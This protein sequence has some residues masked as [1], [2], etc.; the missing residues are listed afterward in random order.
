[1]KQK[2]AE[3]TKKEERASKKV[4]E[5][6]EINLTDPDRIRHRLIEGE[7]SLA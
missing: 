1:V 7:L 2:N 6:Q 5:E 4:H 3:Q